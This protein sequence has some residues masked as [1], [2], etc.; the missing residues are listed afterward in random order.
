MKKQELKP[1]VAYFVSSNNR[2][3][4]CYRDSYFDITKS[5]AQHR[6]YVVFENGEPRTPYRNKSSVYMT[7][8]K[9]YGDVCP[10]HT[11][12]NGYRRCPSKEYRLMDIKSEFWATIKQ[13]HDQRI[14]ERNAKDIRAER[15]ARIA[16]RERQ[17]TRDEISKEFF[18]AINAA[19]GDTKSIYGGVYAWTKFGDLSDDKMKALIAAL[20]GKAVA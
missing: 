11:E 1:G 15:L 4:W 6:Y 13:L 9:N 2:S 16:K 17:A 12:E 14:V 10:T 20:S 3:I 18:A 19:L 5:N 7:T 8:C